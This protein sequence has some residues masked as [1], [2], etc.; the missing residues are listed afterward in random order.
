MKEQIKILC[1]EI[2]KEYDFKIIFAVGYG[3]RAWRLAKKDQR[4]RVGFVFAKK[5]EKNDAG[6]EVLDD[7]IKKIL[8][9]R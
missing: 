1:E 2:E 5:F 6:L 9:E 8:L 3:P 7:R 4:F